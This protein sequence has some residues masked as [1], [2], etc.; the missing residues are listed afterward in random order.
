[1]NDA[2]YAISPRD[3]TSGLPCSAVISRAR[4]SWCSSIRSF[5]RRSTLARSFAVF[6]RHAGIAA[7]AAAIA[8]RV[9]VAPMSGTVPIA[10][11]VAGLVTAMTLPLS[12]SHHWPST[13]ACCLKRPASARAMRSGWALGFMGLFSVG[14][15][16]RT[17]RS[18]D[19][20]RISTRRW[21]DS[22]PAPLGCRAARCCDNVPAFR[23]RHEP[24]LPHRPQPAVG[25]FRAPR[26]RAARGRRRRRRLDPLRR[27]GQPL[28]PEPDLRPDGVPGAEAARGDGRGGE[29]ADRRAPDG[30]AGR[31][32]RHRVR[33][34]RCRPDQL[35]PRREHAR[36]PHAAADPRR[37]LPSRA[38]VQS[39]GAYRRRRMGDRQG[40]PAAR[41]ERQP[42][43]RRAELHRFGTRQDRAAAPDH[44]RVG[45]RHPARSRRR[46]QGRQH[47]PRRR[48]RRRHLRRRQRDLRP[49][50]LR[51][52]DRGDARGAGCVITAG[53]A[54]Q[55]AIVDLDGT[56]VDTVGDFEV[57]LNRM[58][59]DLG[60]G[61]IDRGFIA[62]T[63]GKG[64]DYLIRA[65]LAQVGADPALADA[66]WQRYQHHYQEINGE[67]STVF[68][69][70]AE[71]LQRLVAAGLAL[72]C[73][74][75]KPTAFARALLA[76]KRLDAYFAVVFGG[77]AFARKKPDPLPLLAT[78]RA[79]GSAPRRTLM[80][81]DSANDA[82]AA[83][84]AGCDV[85][86]VT[87]GYNHGEPILDVPARQHIDRLDALVL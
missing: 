44:R 67:Y 62:R 12:A 47:P 73:L 35:P 9:S 72:G 49:E 4:S 3:S 43:L 24:H 79:L 38:G 58:L 46:H 68:P 82:A 83:R 69:G 41:D 14:C 21:V 80:I 34:G 11:P 50:G 52:G 45:A 7:S 33:A 28:R 5:H 6:A 76:A 54:W 87:Y 66:A 25:R 16:T 18:V 78:C 48:C 17:H 26:R 27:D 10:S 37:R 30:A 59:A 22:R 64:S 8:R 84:A 13:K 40:R 70:V 19:A 57:A 51:A 42:G 85:V 56:M 81:G 15:A 77:D 65:T 29:G 60:L 63:V 55:A 23:V 2:A 36:R 20:S 86:L 32:A 53:T 75:N 1:M 61:P 74:T 31:R 39:G 71:G